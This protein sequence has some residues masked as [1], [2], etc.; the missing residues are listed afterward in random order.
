MALNNPGWITNGIGYLSNQGY[1]P[2][3]TTGTTAIGVFTIALPPA[4]PVENEDMEW[5]RVQV[6]EIR[7]LAFAA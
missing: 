7:E 6:E 4:P 2:T 3:I 5:L 1:Y